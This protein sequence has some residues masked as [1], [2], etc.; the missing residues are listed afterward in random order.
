[1][2][3]GLGHERA[4][5]DASQKYKRKRGYKNPASENKGLSEKPA[6]RDILDLAHS[7]AMVDQARVTQKL[8]ARSKKSQMR[9]PAR[10]DLH[11]LQMPERFP[12]IRSQGHRLNMAAR[13]VSL[14]RYAGLE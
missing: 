7:S 6:S 5:G 2:L 11:L 12:I 13:A 8:T 3:G 10:A 1:M 14:P 4:R 9:S